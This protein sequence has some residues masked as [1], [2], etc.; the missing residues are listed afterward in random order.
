MK[1]KN[2]ITLKNKRECYPERGIP[3]KW[4]ASEIGL[5]EETTAK[6]SKEGITTTRGMGLWAFS[7]QRQQL[8][9]AGGGRAWGNHLDDWFGTLIYSEWA[10]PS[11]SRDIC[12]QTELVIVYAWISDSEKSLED[13]R[14]AK[15]RQYLSSNISSP[16]II[17][18]RDRKWKLNPQTGQ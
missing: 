2:L 12:P 15:P 5:L 13:C 9:G 16:S 4:W 18:P 17:I 7:A 1:K 10:A 11:S 8:Q 3:E 6:Q 14:A